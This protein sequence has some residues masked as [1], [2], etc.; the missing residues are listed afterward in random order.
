MLPCRIK[1]FRISVIDRRTQTTIYIHLLFGYKDSTNV[2][3]FLASNRRNVYIQ[4]ITK[5]CVPKI[6][7]TPAK[8]PCFAYK[9]PHILS[10]SHSHFYSPEMPIAH[11]TPHIQSENYLFTYG[12]RWNVVYASTRTHKKIKKTIIVKSSVN[13]IVESSARAACVYVRR[14]EQQKQMQR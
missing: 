6:F 12:H 8:I 5:Q 3:I 1:S 10:Q 7:A 9:M 2:F 4:K 14:K 11:I 13:H